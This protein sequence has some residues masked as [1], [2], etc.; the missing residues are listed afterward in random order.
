VNWILALLSAVL[1]TASFPGY[2]L[3]ALA[4]L[5]L[6]PL[7]VASARESGWR[8][9]FLLGYVSGVL[10][11]FVTCN[12]IHFTIE[13]HGGMSRAAAWFCFALFCLAKALQF[14]GFALL[15]GWTMR[16]RFAIPATAAVWVLIDYTNAPL[17]FAWLSLG[18]AT[19]D[20]G[21]PVRL[22]PWTGVWGITFLLASLSA[23]LANFLG[24]RKGVPFLGLALIP[25]LL[26]LP[27]LPDAAGRERA[28][29]V[30]PNIDETQNW[31]P[32]SLRRL[33]DRMRELSLAPLA[34]SPRPNLLIW[35]EAP[36]PFYDYDLGFMHDLE[37]IAREGNT[38]FLAG[39]V[40]HAEDGALLNSADLVS[41]T[42]EVLSRYDKVNLVPFGE[43][44]PWPLGPIAFKISTEAGDFRPGSRRIVTRL[45]DGHKLGTFICYESVFPSFI[46]GFAREGAQVLVNPSNDGWFGKTAAREQHLEIVR[47]RAAENRRWILRAT[48]DGITATIDPGGRV[49]EKL[50]LYRESSA[51]MHFSYEAGV[52]FY[53]RFGDWFVWVC[54]AIVCAGM[55]SAR[56]WV[57]LPAR[58]SSSETPSGP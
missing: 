29:L 10:Y 18:N 1:L 35:P 9:R 26:L 57:R 25:S 12:W 37:G 2:N 42:G 14:G 20:M 46:A 23:E 16:S 40:G 51:S 28:V 8:K 33:I 19:I 21:L 27:P 30:Q 48:N 47:M 32:Q 58:S 41:P 54:L 4:P 36:A 5:A 11:W 34:S 44:V 13:T 56:P 52:T 31:T 55:V 3:I 6:A 24:K 45:D 39:L 15:A 49:R 38:Y 7:I 22:A 17:G 43:F 50:D 53:S